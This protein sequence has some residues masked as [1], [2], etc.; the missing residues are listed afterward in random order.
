MG[1]L[2]FH[3]SK[4]EGSRSRSRDDDDVHWASQLVL[5][6]PENFAHQ[7]PDTAARG[8]RADASAGRD[9]KPGRRV[10]A[11]SRE[12]DE[13]RSQAAPTV[14][15]EREKLAALPQAMRAGKT[16]RRRYSGAVQPG[17]FG[18]MVTVSRLRPLSRRRF[19]TLRPPGV[20]IRVR[21]P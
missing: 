7:P 13:I 1:E 16:L 21:N 15:F 20:A 18:G 9:A 5:A 14:A 6:A 4:V 11:V 17:C 8:R 19:S 3:L 10:P 12:D 2:L